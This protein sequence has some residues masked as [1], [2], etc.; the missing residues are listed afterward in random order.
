MSHQVI[1]LFQQ[2]GN[3]QL[4]S[5]LIGF[6]AYQHH[7]LFISQ[8]NPTPLLF[9]GQTF[10]FTF[11]HHS[12]LVY[13]HQTLNMLVIHLS[14]MSQQLLEFQAHG[15]AQSLFQS[16]LLQTS[17][18][19]QLLFS[20]HNQTLLLSQLKVS[21]IGHHHQLLLLF[22]HQTSFYSEQAHLFMHQQLL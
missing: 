13:Q 20:Q 3:P 8:A 4:L 18:L 2:F 12:L 1:F 11:Q 6:Q 21:H 7:K 16:V 19:H 14:S 15:Q 17:Q 5:Q 9:H 10:Q 22:H